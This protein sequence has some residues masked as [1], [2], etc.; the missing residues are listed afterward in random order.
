[1]IMSMQLGRAHER[2]DVCAAAVVIAAAVRDCDCLSADTIA[3]LD[4]AADWIAAAPV[5]EGRRE[6]LLRQSV[7]EMRAR[8]W[9]SREYA[10]AS[11]SSSDAEAGSDAGSDADADAPPPPPFAWLETERSF[12]FG[13]GV[14]VDVE[15]APVP[16]GTD[17]G[18][19][20]AARTGCVVWNCAL[21][22]ALQLR[23]DLLNASTSSS[24]SLPPLPPRVVE[25]G[26]GVGV[27]GL[28]AAMSGARAVVCTDLPDCLP[29]LRRNVAYRPSPCAVAP[30]IWGDAEQLDTVLDVLGDLGADGAPL[31]VV[32]SD[33]AYFTA[34]HRDLVATLVDLA[35]R[36]HAA[37]T[38]CVVWIAHQ[39]RHRRVEQP[40]FV[41]LLP[42][43]GFDVVEVPLPAG[44][45]G[46]EAAASLFGR[47][48]SG[49]SGACDEFSGVVLFRCT[50]SAP[51]P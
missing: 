19:G 15:Q 40:F 35:A 3:G 37:R 34:A 10:A 38:P 41:K 21:A 48:P 33:V 22:L 32:A 16:R 45:V 27:V 8:G 42:A 9:R 36:A 39:Y 20:R 29:L 24:S 5:G 4:A 51:T 12:H 17:S 14:R 30:L 44:C 13:D 49:A 6:A 7:S 43:S 25:L 28:V 11:G 1:M 26:A 46:A 50:W 31:W 47:R 23:A 18:M 2:G